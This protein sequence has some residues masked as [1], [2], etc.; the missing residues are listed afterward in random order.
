MTTPD[1]FAEARNSNDLRALAFSDLLKNLGATAWELDF[2][3]RTASV[4]GEG[5]ARLGIQQA[6][7]N[8]VDSLLHVFHEDDRKQLRSAF[9]KIEKTATRFQIEVRLTSGKASARWVL[10]HGRAIVENQVTRGAFGYLVEIT[11]RV[12]QR[13][14]FHESQQRFKAIFNQT[15][16]FIGLL[17]RDGTLIEAN[18]TALDFGGVALYEVQGNKFW[19]TPWWADKGEVRQ[20]L[21]HSIETAAKGKLVRYEAEMIGSSG[22]SITVELTIRPVMNEENQVIYLIPEARDITDKKEVHEQLILLN[23]DLELKIEQRTKELKETIDD[24]E[25]FA[26]SVSHDLRTPLRAIK[27][28]ST[29]VQ[30]DYGSQL[31]EGGNRLIKNIHENAGKM[32]QLIDDLL[33]F[34]R[35]S[36]VALQP[37]SVDMN[38][39]FGQALAELR[40]HWPNSTVRL[41]RLPV[42]DGDERLLYQVVMNL[43]GNA[44]KYSSKKEASIIHVSA[45]EENGAFQF[46]VRDNGIGFDPDFASGLFNVFNRLNSGK[47]FEG[48]GVGLSIVKKII[49]KHGGKVWAEGKL[50]EGATFYFSIPS[51]ES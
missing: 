14:L 4:S 25:S 47:E 18:E 16:Q 35:T 2:I 30:D 33:L 13:L 11:E 12:H 22:Y 37:T 10:V 36:R 8:S 9:S 28:F 50:Q 24:L 44:M 31:D 27:G 43:L 39:V 32:G 5:A 49:D 3:D 38:E 45:V 23:R 17:D 51:S 48:T 26:Y 42:V 6:T 21:I 7:I 1:G 20:Q 19:D 29:I 40:H 34:S 15:F 46:A 41:E